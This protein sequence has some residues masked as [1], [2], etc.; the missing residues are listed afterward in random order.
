MGSLKDKR[1]GG[2]VGRGVGQRVGIQVVRGFV[3]TSVLGGEGKKEGDIHT[4]DLSARRII[5]SKFP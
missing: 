4:V 3:D 5:C 1:V 2:L